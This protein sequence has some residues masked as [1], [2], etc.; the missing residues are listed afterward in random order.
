M[1]IINQT[2]DSIELMF[3]G[4]IG[5]WMD[6]DVDW[7]VRDFENYKKQGIKNVT[8]Y[9]NS[10]GGEVIQGQAL[11]AYMNRSDFNITWVIDGIAASMMAMLITNPAH[12]VV[13]NK[14][15][16]FMYHRISGIVRGNADDVIAYADMMNKFE[17]DLIDMF[18]TRTK[19]DKK[20]VQKNY[21]KNTDTWLSADEALAIGIVNEIIEGKTGIKEPE[22]LSDS[23]EVYNFY[24][25][26]LTNFNQKQDKMKKVAL[27]LNLAENANEDAV[28]TAVENIL[29]A[30]KTHASTLAEKDRQIAELNTT[31]ENT[32]KLRV[33]NLIDKA[34]ENKKFGE[35]LRDTYTKLATNDFESAELVINKMSGVAP[36]IDSLTNEKLPEVEKNWK[37]DDFHKANKLENLKNT[38]KAHFIALYKEKFGK[39]YKD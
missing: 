26:Q 2:S 29:N 11:F 20:Q 8:I 18:A 9:V 14:Y 13:A 16:K 12:K 10:D 33:K 31:I 39:E 21:F 19:M 4:I 17:A 28:A 6:I 25:S 27:L 23:R 7:L 38:N 35:D 1:K 34:I 30:N 37:W 5:K 15:S 36:V 22:N 32:S 24:N 3:Y